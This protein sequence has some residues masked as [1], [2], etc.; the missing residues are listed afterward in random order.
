MYLRFK[1]R[2]FFTSTE[3]GPYKSDV[4][5]SNGKQCIE[6]EIK[7][8]KSDLKN[9]LKKKKHLYYLNSKTASKYIP[10][11]F[12]FV[13]TSKLIKTAKSITKNTPYGIILVSD[14]DPKKDN[15]YSCLIYKKAKTLNNNYNKLLERSII[16]RMSSELIN[17]RIKRYLQ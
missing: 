1:R 14:S 16:M 11:C 3:V 10:N 5:C 17:L 2:F 12:Y 7:V 8:S 15:N 4:L 6:F 13:V 9:D